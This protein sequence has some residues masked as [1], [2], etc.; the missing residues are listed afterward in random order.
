M[1]KLPG[2]WRRD[3]VPA[4]LRVRA[5]GLEALVSAVEGRAV[6]RVALMSSPAAALGALNLGPYAASA[7]IDAYASR[8]A[9]LRYV[10]RARRNHRAGGSRAATA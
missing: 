9:R 2:N 10:D 5:D 7:V 4:H 6:G 3:G 1:R 8:R